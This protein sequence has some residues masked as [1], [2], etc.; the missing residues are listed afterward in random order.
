MSRSE[1]P[2]DLE[3]YIESLDE[4]GRTTF[5]SGHFEFKK[6]HLGFTAIAMEGYGGPNIS[7]TLSDETLS[8]LRSMGLDAEAIDELITALQRKIMEGTAHMQLQPVEG[9]EVQG[10]SHNK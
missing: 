9:N 3:V 10:D 8:S 1:L 7:A 5:I 2:P 6:N 4:Q